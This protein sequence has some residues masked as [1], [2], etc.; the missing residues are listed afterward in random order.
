[1]VDMRTGDNGASEASYC[2]VRLAGPGDVE[3]LMALRLA[4]AAEKGLEAE[5]PT[6]GERFAAWLDQEREG[7]VFWIAEVD[8]EPVGM[9]NLAIFTRMP[10]VKAV[11]FKDSWGYLGNLF[12][13]PQH[14]GHRVGRDLIAACTAYADANDFARIV[15]SPSHASIPLYERA[16]FGAAAELMVRRPKSGS[17]SIE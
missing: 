16:G 13:L 10:Y 17:D 9:V 4:W 7:R 5:D 11:T 2:R 6:F 15:L 3:A 8:S 14:R 12:V 1:M